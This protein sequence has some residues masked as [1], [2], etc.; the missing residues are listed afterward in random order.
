[1]AEL[2]YPKS[3]ELTTIAQELMPRLEQNRPIFSLFPTVNTDSSILMW[4]QEDDF[5]GLQYARGLNGQPTR[6]KKIGFKR[7]MMQPGYYGE[8]ENIDE[9]EMT[10]RRQFGT[11]NTPVQLTDLVT[12]AAARL[13]GREVDRKEVNLWTLLTTGT[14]SVTGPTG[15]IV[16]TDIFPLQTMT[17]TTPW[18]TKATATPLADLQALA[19]LGRGRSV[20]FGAGCSIWVNQVTANNVIGNTNAN[21]LGGRRLGLGTLNNMRDV[22]T[23]LTGDGLANFNVYDSGYKDESGTFQL[24]IPNGKA[25]AIGQRPAGQNIGEYR[26]LRNAN[27]PDFGAGS[28]T[29]VVDNIDDEVPRAVAVHRGHTGGPVIFFPTAIVIMNV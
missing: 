12:R 27:N 21:D 18:S 6:I 26:V 9:S 2:I 15:A 1:M 8:F 14:F 5:T 24:Y 7:Y 13:L 23:L 16:H 17:P 20:N 10:I 19:L 3:W 22:N 28:Y 25:I 11:V 29:K 4:D